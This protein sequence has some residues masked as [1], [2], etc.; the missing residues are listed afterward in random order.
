MSN[1]SVLVSCF[2]LLMLA[3]DVSGSA[4]S[5]LPMPSIT[6]ETHQKY[7]K[8][9]RRPTKSYEDEKTTFLR[10]LEQNATLPMEIA[11]LYPGYGTHYAYIYV[12]TPPKRQ[13]VIIDTGSHQT[14]FPCEGTTSF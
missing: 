6:L 5:S 8:Y 4:D 14:A 10:G 9:M 7:G 1:M 3:V 2:A 13:S 12:G 11:P